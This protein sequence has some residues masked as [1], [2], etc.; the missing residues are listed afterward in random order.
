MPEKIPRMENWGSMINSWETK[1]RRRTS[2]M[3]LAR[4]KNPRA[5]RKMRPRRVM[6]SRITSK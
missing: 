5:I 1:L 4:K 6:A 3:R 2:L